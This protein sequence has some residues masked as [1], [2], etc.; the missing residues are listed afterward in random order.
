MATTTTTAQQWG[1]ILQPPSSPMHP[2]RPHTAPANSANSK[3]AF[4]AANAD[5]H[6]PR[7]RR[8]RFAP[9]PDPRRAVLITDDGDELPIPLPDDNTFPTSLLLPTVAS[10][11]TQ[12]SPTSATSAAGVMSAGATGAFQL[13]DS[14]QQELDGSSGSSTNSYHSSTSSTPRTTTPSEYSPVS[15]V[16]SS[17]VA[18]APAALPANLQGPTSKSG[19]SSTSASATG[20]YSVPSPSSGAPMPQPKRLS[21]LRPFRK[22]SGT[23][24]SSSSS[25]SHSLTPTPS[26]ESP[27]GSSSTPTPTSATT[28][29]RKGLSGLTAEEILTLGTINLF[30]TGSRDSA[31]SSST[32][33]TNNGWGL[34]R[35]ASAGNN[36]SSEGGSGS[37][38][39][40][41]QSTQSYKSK[42]K[43]RSISGSLFS[44]PLASSSSTPG[45]SSS[46]SNKNKPAAP[47]VSRHKGTRMLN[48]RVYGS[49]R[50]GG[51]P[52]PF[53]NARDEEPEFVEWGYGGMGSAKSARSAGA[54]S[55]VNWERVAGA[56]DGA[57]RTGVGGTR[58]SHGDGN[59]ALRK[60]T[61]FGGTAGLGTVGGAVEEDD[62]SG[63]G[64]V[65]RRREERER[66]AREA[67]EKE[68]KEKAEA[69]AK[70]ASASDDAR[71][72]G[73]E[74]KD[75]ADASPEAT[76][77]KNQEQ[78]P[79]S[80]ASLSLE[81]MEIV[82]L[83][84]EDPSQAEE[85]APQPVST[86]EKQS[87]PVKELDKEKYLSTSNMPTPTPTRSS[88][89]DAA[90]FMALT[91]A[92]SPDDDVTPQP[93]QANP[94]D[95]QASEEHE[96]DHIPQ[97][98]PVPMRKHHH[99]SHSHS[100]SREEKAI[101]SG[102]TSASGA[103]DASSLGDAPAHNAKPEDDH[104]SSSSSSASDTDSDSEQGDEDGGNRE[105]EDDEDEDDEDEAAQKEADERRKTMLGAGVEK[106]MRHK[107]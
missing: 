51:N 100:H 50:A 37:A 56:S 82:I 18:P 87:L 97:V 31:D 29:M 43:S 102:I 45:S 54:A 92:S 99:H 83:Q 55:G 106:V 42:S 46:S 57:A 40:R 49:K 103:A 81:P 105:D 22:S 104:V 8:I 107:E 95:Q 79:Q 88:T 6:G 63:M 75:E 91:S 66:K 58:R 44:S 7:S 77:E 15:S 4:A 86:E 11:S 67:K 48:G 47:P 61:G 21:L 41:T 59:D 26:I 52:N 14:S 94:F 84:L 24:S 23:S 34:A 68:E 72:G 17:P 9:L 89:V 5:A 74:A 1:S 69:A 30:R 28:A 3:A 73:P 36:G 13:A 20:T 85:T 65:K 38:L 98:V 35:W 80:A 71:A 70:A 10:C 33:T 96:P 27:S 60:E 78:Q 12:T 25:S 2:R 62:G 76:V 53:A 39:F 93:H 101:L 32:A 90:H 19:D 16:G 64:W